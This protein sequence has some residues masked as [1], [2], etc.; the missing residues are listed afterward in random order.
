M[1]SIFIFDSFSF[2]FISFKILF[3]DEKIIK[4]LEKKNSFIKSNENKILN[5]I[6]LKENGSK[7]KIEN[8][9]KDLLLLRDENR[10]LKEN[11]ISFEEERKTFEISLLKLKNVILLKEKDIEENNKK[12][13]FILKKHKFDFYILQENHIILQKKAEKAVKRLN[14]VHEAF[15]KTNDDNKNLRTE[16]EN[17]LVNKIERENSIFVP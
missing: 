3:S 5:E 4:E 1:F 17:M 12:F 7:I 13:D 11:K 10:T 16:M 6:N 15:L 2:R 14:S 9:Q 8:M